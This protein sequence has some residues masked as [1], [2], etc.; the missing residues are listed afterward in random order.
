MMTIEQDT[1]VPIDM[2]KTEMMTV[3]MAK[4]ATD[5]MKTKPEAAAIDDIDDSKTCRPASPFRM[6]NMIPLFL[7]MV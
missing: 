7:Q 5:T 4:R 6:G 1:S 2:I 3:V